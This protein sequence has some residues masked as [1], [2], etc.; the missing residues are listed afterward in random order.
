MFQF[1]PTWGIKD[2][3]SMEKRFLRCYTIALKF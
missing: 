3:E 1:G 2:E